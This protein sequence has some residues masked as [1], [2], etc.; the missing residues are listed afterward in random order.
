MNRV[1]IVRFSRQIYSAFPLYFFSFL[2]SFTGDIVDDPDKLTLGT[3][4]SISRVHEDDL[5]SQSSVARGIAWSGR[6]GRSVYKQLFGG[7]CRF[8]EHVYLSNI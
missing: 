7:K 2:F 6:T 8:C 3:I 4:S 5:S 1:A